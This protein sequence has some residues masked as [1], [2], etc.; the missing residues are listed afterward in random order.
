MVEVQRIYDN[1]LYDQEYDATPITEV[2]TLVDHPSWALPKKAQYLFGTQNS[3]TLLSSEL[4]SSSGWTS[5]GWTGDSS[6]GFTH[7][8]GNTSVLSNTMAAIID[9]VYQITLGVTGRTA[10]TF[11]VSFGGESSL[12]ITSTQIYSLTAS[13]NGNLQITPTTDFNGTIV[14]G[15]RQLT[16]ELTQAELLS[17]LGVSDVVQLS[18]LTGYVQT[19][20]G[21]S[22][23]L[24]TEITR[25]SSIKQ[26]VYEIL[27][28]ASG[29]V[30]GRISGATLP[31]GWVIA[32]DSS[33]NL[34]ITHTLS[35][36][37]IASVN[38]YE[39]NGLNERQ[40]KPFSDAFTGVLANGQTVLVEGLDTEALA[41]RIELI[42]S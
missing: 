31:S 19:V 7:T 25:L 6:L 15:I 30:S 11:T 13:T 21:K 38:V 23:I 34:L 5:I 22:L 33:V 36:Q 8:A 35:G 32:V 20:S 10:G 37:K 14:V 24:D 28:P 18:Q 16:W 3:D 9:K 1:D 39:I 41:L 2:V 27:L 26:N 4:V 40:A 42:F 12:A 17:I 29:T